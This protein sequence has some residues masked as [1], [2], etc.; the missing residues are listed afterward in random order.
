MTSILQGKINRSY[1]V[2]Q[3][4]QLRNEGKIHQQTAED[5]ADYR[6]HSRD[7]ASKAYNRFAKQS[8]AVRSQAALLSATGVLEGAAPLP[9]RT[10]WPRPAPQAVEASR[11]RPVVEVEQVDPDDPGEPV[12]VTESGDVAP[13]MTQQ[14]GD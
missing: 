8:K 9:F 3:T 6:R 7:V 14:V 13:D 12:D 10:L 11:P 4:E 2:L 5:L 1:H